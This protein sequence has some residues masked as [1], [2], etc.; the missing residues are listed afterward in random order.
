MKTTFATLTALAVASASALNVSAGDREWATA[1]KIL[2]GVVA[3]AVIARSF[4]P[5]P[6]YETRVVY[7]PQPATVVYVPP[8]AV[9]VQP[10]PVVVYRR[11]L[12]RNVVYVA[13]PPVVYVQPPRVG[14]HLS[15][16]PHF[17]AVPVYR[18]CD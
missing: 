17:H 11:P 9:V 5:A 18:V 13:P 8:P 7:E 14:F 2:T 6:V 12:R 1:G 15:F 3:G 16:G 10:A 4:E